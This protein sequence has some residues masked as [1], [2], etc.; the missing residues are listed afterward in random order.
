MDFDGLLARRFDHYGLQ[1]TLSQYALTGSTI[2]SYLA[3]LMDEGKMRLE[4]SG[5]RLFWRTE[6]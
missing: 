6:K 4:I 1:K 5:N 2:R 3:Y